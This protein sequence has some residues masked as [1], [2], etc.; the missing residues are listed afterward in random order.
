M[1][2]LKLLR[3]ESFCDNYKRA[4]SILIQC[5]FPVALLLAERTNALYH[6]FLT[7]SRVDFVT[8]IHMLPQG[9]GILNPQ[10]NIGDHS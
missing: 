8:R 9:V 1:I 6:L 3:S 2:P 7:P 10:T 5:T 4:D